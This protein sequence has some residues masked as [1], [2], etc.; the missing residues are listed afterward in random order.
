MNRR[1]YLIPTSLGHE[2]DQQ[3]ARQNEIC[4]SCHSEQYTI[5]KLILYTRGS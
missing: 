1:K 4:P 2:L 5:H 3:Q